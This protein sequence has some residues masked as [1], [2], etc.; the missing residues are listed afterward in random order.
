M[1]K[2]TAVQHYG[3]MTAVAEALGVS[4]S[5]VSQWGK[6]VPLESALALETL[7]NGAVKVERSQYPHLAR[8]DRQVA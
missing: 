2:A 1:L 6:V 3:T 4:I 8:A 7:S 5:A